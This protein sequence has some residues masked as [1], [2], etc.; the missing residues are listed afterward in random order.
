MPESEVNRRKVCSGR[1]NKKRTKGHKKKI[2]RFVLRALRVGGKVLPNF[3][4]KKGK[5]PCGTLRVSFLFWIGNGEKGQG[6]PRRTLSGVTRQSRHRDNDGF[7]LKEK[8]S[9][10]KGQKKGMGLKRRLKRAIIGRVQGYK[11][12]RAFQDSHT[13]G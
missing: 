13:G 9:Q 4:G 5:K 1:E 2:L 10:C 6:R 8:G 11:T 7:L 12:K 3:W